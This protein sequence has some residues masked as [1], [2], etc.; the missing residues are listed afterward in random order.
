[1]TLPDFLAPHLAARNAVTVT[2]LPYTI[3]RVLHFSNGG[4]IYAGRDTRTG[5]QVVLKEGRPHAG[6]DGYGHDAVRRLERE[7]EILQRLAGI[8]GIPAVHDL[9][10]V[11]EHRFLVMDYVEG[12]VLG[13]AIVLRYPLIDPTAGPAD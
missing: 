9:R 1:V 6:L 12:E 2:D 11:G 7:H 10:W 4:G 8:P 5:A 3:E 13:Q